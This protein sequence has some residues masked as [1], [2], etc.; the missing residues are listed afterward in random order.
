VSARAS[1]AW[2]AAA[3]AVTVLL[4][5]GFSDSLID[6]AFI[7]FRYADHVL[8]GHGPVFN[9]GERVEGFTS[10]LWLGLLAAGRAAGIPYTSLVVA[11]GTSFALGAVACTW[12]LARAVL[13]PGPATLLPPVL[14]ALHPAFSMWAVHGLETSLFVMLVTAGAA[15]WISSWRGSEV[16]AGAILGL[17]FCTRPE[18]ALFFAIL[19]CAA[20][21]R[22]GLAR[23]SK[24]ALGFAIPALGLEVARWRYYG[25]LLP[26]TFHAK[27]GG[28][29]GRLMFGLSYA[30]AFVITHLPLVILCGAAAWL[31]LRPRRVPSGERTHPGVPAGIVDSFVLGTA[32]SAY[33]IWMGGD[34]FPGYRFWLPI[35]PFA[36]VTAAWGL[37][38][39]FAARREWIVPASVVTVVV[40][41]AAS[42]PAVLLEY[43]TG[44][45]FTAK[46]TAA[47]RWLQEHA[48]PGTTLAVNYVGA[49]PYHSRLPTIDMLGLTDAAVGRTP[50]RGRFRFP[51]HAKGNGAAVLDRAPDLIL[52][53]GVYLESVPME[54]LSPEL[55]TEEEI[56]ADPRFAADY[57]RVEVRIPSAGDGDRFFAF[58]KRKEMPWKPR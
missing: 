41:A 12:L 42:T 3:A 14:L 43:R 22:R 26:N 4:C 13:P 36:G 7:F 24:L 19:A 30:K 10:P 31:A 46:M 11:L 38:Q 32:W 56:A 37:E 5:A 39:V 48:P 58:Y 8:A 40:V 18:A 33:V 1:A 45:D 20:V 54:E 23:A 17:A 35:L 9:V 53:N 25:E 29:I 51:G 16:V 28:G 21:W 34:G 15:A 52:M 47:G 6:D 49:L 57:E 2:T 50:I 44:R 55:T 27:T